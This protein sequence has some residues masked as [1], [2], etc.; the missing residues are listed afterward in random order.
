MQFKNEKALNDAFEV[1]K[2][3]LEVEEITITE[4]IEKEGI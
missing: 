3:T 1:A 4:E 2:V